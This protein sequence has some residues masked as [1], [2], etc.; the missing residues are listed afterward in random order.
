MVLED[1]RFK[2]REVMNMSKDYVCH[3]LIKSTLG[4]EKAVCALRVMF[5]HVRPTTCSNEDFHSYFGVV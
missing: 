4:H 2:V 1:R 5:A 3:I